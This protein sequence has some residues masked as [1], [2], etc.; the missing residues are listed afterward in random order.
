MK[1]YNKMRC[2]LACHEAEQLTTEDVY[3]LLLYGL[4]GYDDNTNKEI[5]DMFVGLW[6]KDQI[7]YK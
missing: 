3:E 2:A 7:P 1:D 4:A 5:E 6:G